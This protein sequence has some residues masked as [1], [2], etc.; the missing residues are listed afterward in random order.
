MPRIAFFNSGGV[1][2]AVGAHVGRELAT[3]RMIIEYV[4]VRSDNAAWRR[5]EAEG[6]DDAIFCDAKDVADLARLKKHHVLVL[7]AKKCGLVCLEG[8]HYALV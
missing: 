5:V 3:I 6:V 1:D 8:L 4:L 2:F 7:G